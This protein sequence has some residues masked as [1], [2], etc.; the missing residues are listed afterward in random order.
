M[1]ETPRLRLVVPEARH[2]D[3]LTRIL[4]DAEVM[5]Q[6]VRAPTLDSAE[7]SLVR[8]AGYRRDRGLGFWAVEVDGD[9]AGFCGLKPGGAGTPIDGE[10]EIG[11]VLDKPYWG[12][13]MA[14]EAAGATLSWAWSNRTE[15]R[16]VAI[17]GAT[18]AGSRRVMDRLGMR[19]LPELDFDHPNYA[20]HDPMRQSVVYAI[21]RPGV[22]AA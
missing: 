5:A 16:I 18:H 6:L 17:T 7:A 3:A 15:P 10:L 2:T 19:H 12:R 11:W 14:T 4:S 1:I 8:H 21:D 9:V 13:G 22:L 20:E